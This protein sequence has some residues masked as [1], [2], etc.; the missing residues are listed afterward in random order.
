MKFRTELHPIS[1]QKKINLS[2]KIVTMGS[3]FSENIGQKLLQNKFE[4]LINPFGVIF[5]PLSVIQLLEWII[6][7][8]NGDVLMDNLENFY[9]QHDEVWY[10]YHLHSKIAS[11]DKEELKPIVKLKAK[12]TF[13]FLEKAD[14]I[15]LTFGTAFM[16]ELLGENGNNKIP[17]SNCH[18]QPKNLFN[19]K[20]IDLEIA[21]VKF[22]HFIKKINLFG[23][24]EKQI[25]ITVSPVRHLKE[26]LVENSVS[27]SILRVLAHFL[28]EKFEN[29]NYFPSYELVLDDLRDY[30]FYESDLLHPNAQ[31][32][33]YIWR[34]FSENYFDDKTQL[35][36][37]KWQKIASSLAHR[38][39]FPNRKSHQDFI[40]KLISDIEKVEKEFKIELKEEIEFLKNNNLKL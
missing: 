39:F 3:C 28:T 11:Q 24:K 7:E 27:K 10:N 19:K 9:I 6:E 21:K 36:L 32:I 17:I 4:T 25:I 31:A 1:L 40:Q 23:E 16:Y 13:E 18:K 38:P 29:V 34:K 8:K 12:Q 30:R 20:L 14:T 2:N 33:E 22:E 5:N 26:G 35:F 37:K 15:I